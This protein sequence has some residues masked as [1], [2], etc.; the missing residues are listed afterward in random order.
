MWE[1]GVVLSGTALLEKGLSL[2]LTH[3]ETAWIITFEKEAV[4]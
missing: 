2:P 4:T 3:P 1:N